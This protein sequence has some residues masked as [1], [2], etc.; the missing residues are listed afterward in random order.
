MWTGRMRDGVDAALTWTTTSIDA[1][2]GATQAAMWT[3]RMRDGVDEALTWTTT[4]I[5]GAQEPHSL[6]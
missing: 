3:G 6:R 1:T 2:R 4:S 5:D